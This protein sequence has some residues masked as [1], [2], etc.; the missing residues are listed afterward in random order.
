MLLLALCGLQDTVFLTEEEAIKTIFPNGET[1]L[2]REVALDDET[3]RAVQKHLKAPTPERIVLFVGVREGKPSGY[4]MI[5][6][7]V[8]KYLPI[9]FIVGVTPEGKVADVAVMVHREHIGAEC[10]AR[11]YLKQFPGKS[12]ES[13]LRRNRDLLTMAGATLSCDA[14]AR[15]TRRVLA[16]VNEH[17]VRR[18]ANVER[19]LQDDVVTQ[20]RMRMGT[21]CTV[22]ARGPNAKAGIEAAF[23]EIKRVEE[24]L[25]DY[26]EG[27]ELSR[28][29]ASGRLEEAS[30]LILEFLRA[31]IDHAK[32]SEG[33]FDVTVGALVDLWGFRTREYRVPT[34]EELRRAAVGYAGVAVE[35]RSVRL[36][37]GLRLDPGGIGKGLAL[38]RALAAM[39]KAGVTDGIVDFGS[40]SVAIGDAGD[41]G[42]GWPVGIRDPFDE[43]AVTGVVRL[44]NEALSVSGGYEKFFEKEGRRY[45]HILDPRTRAPVE[46]TAAT[47]VIAATGTEADAL[48]TAVFVAGGVEIAAKRGAQALVTPIDRSKPASMTPGWKARCRAVDKE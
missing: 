4:A 46:H 29:N 48:S 31:S 27:S 24:T 45:G 38:D 10:A 41:G 18:P 43:R 21:F 23:A 36:A 9:T 6:E 11:R 26:I 35:G 28:L 44:R 20:R 22:S 39:K 13:P 34:D 14:V 47:A 16:I 33:A 7:E 15:G 37:P 2:R 40:T 12:L 42:A 3:R 30:D 1:V 17:C 5:T 25:S 19:L 32:A 8:G